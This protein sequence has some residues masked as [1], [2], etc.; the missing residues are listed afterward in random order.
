MTDDEINRYQSL[1]TYLRY[2]GSKRREHI[3]RAKYAD[4]RLRNREAAR[5]YQHA[6]K[7]VEDW[8]SA[9]EQHVIFRKGRR[10]RKKAV[11]CTTRGRAIPGRPG[12]PGLRDQ[13]IA[14]REKIA[15]GEVL[16]ADQ[17]GIAGSD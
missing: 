8:F 4:T 11:G 12:R 7:I 1:V 9:F 13:A 16:G 14:P 5:C 15:K 6:A 10:G 17:E 2:L 3:K